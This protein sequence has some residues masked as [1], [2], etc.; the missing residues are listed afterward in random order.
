MFS[1]SWTHDRIF[2]VIHHAIDDSLPAPFTINEIVGAEYEQ[3]T[4]GCFLKPSLGMLS[5]IQ[6]H[7][8]MEVDVTKDL[9]L[10]TPVSDYSHQS[11]YHYF[12]TVK[13]AA[14]ATSS[15]RVPRN[16]YSFLA[17]Y[18]YPLDSENEQTFDDPFMSARV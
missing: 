18:D 11:K 9:L 6:A 8:N 3:L 13:T 16:F 5:L 12:G 2:S 7:G 4:S 1:R 17:Q 10:M 14:K 15:S